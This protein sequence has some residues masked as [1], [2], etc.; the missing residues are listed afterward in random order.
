VR[1]DLEA[2]LTTS[3]AAVVGRDLL[4]DAG[5]ALYDAPAVVLM[6]GTQPDPIFCYANRTAQGLWG[7]SWAEFIAL[8]SRLSAQAEAQAER[9]RLLAAARACGFIADYAGIRIAKDGRRFR[10]ADVVLWNV[11]VGG[12]RQGQAAVFRSWTWLTPG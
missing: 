3:Y 2:L 12:E 11:V 6:H 9:E 4:A 1:P 5:G 7:Y 10:I 8:P